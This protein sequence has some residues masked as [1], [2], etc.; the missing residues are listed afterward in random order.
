MPFILFEKGQPFD[1]SRG[2]SSLD[3]ISTSSVDAPSTRSSDSYQSQSEVDSLV[4]ALSSPLPRARRTRP[5]ISNAHNNSSS[6]SFEQTIPPRDGNFRV[7]DSGYPIRGVKMRGVDIE[8]SA[9]SSSTPHGSTGRAP[10]ARMSQKNRVTAML[11][12]DD[13]AARE[14]SAGSPSDYEPPSPP[15]R[16]DTPEDFPPPHIST[17]G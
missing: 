15:E 7:T 17:D 9:S 16:A 12:A 10:A 3:S 8:A 4:Q 5:A 11:V 1:K 2:T 6:E 14:D 13:D